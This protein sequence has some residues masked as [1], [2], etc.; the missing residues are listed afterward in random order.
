MPPCFVR[1]LPDDL[2]ALRPFYSAYELRANPIL[3]TYWMEEHMWLGLAIAAGYLAFCYVGPLVMAGRSAIAPKRILMAWNLLLAVFSAVG[4]L[5]TAP[6]LLYYASKHGLYASVRV[7]GG[8]V[9]VG[10]VQRLGRL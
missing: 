8:R 2:P 5:R 10:R 3:Q 1:Q 7:W 4:F 9:W 6:H